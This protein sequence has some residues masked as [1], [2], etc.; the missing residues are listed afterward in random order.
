MAD[1]K[2]ATGSTLLAAGL[3][4]TAAAWVA[5][6]WTPIVVLGSLVCVAGVWLLAAGWLHK[7]DDSVL[8]TPV[9]DATVVDAVAIRQGSG[10]YLIQAVV[11]AGASGE[12]RA[13]LVGVPGSTPPFHDRGTPLYWQDY[14]GKTRP[15]VKG[16]TARLAIALAS[17]PRGGW[18]DVQ[19][20]AWNPDGLAESTYRLNTNPMKFLVELY[21]D[22]GEWSSG[23]HVVPVQRGDGWLHASRPYPRHRAGGAEER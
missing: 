20:N 13:A 21:S 2:L 7:D 22:E 9:R 19:V 17:T 1:R 4:I 8:P 6:G 3:V 16:E 10:G 14:Q 23:E 18:E 12:Y 5:P 15:I 11:K